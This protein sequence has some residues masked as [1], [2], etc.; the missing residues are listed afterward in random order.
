MTTAVYHSVLCCYLYSFSSGAKQGRKPRRN[1]WCGFDLK[2]AGEW[3][4][5]WWR[6]GVVFM[7]TLRQSQPNKAGLECLFVCAYMHK[8][9]FMYVRMSV[10]PQK[11][12]SISIKFDMWVAVDEWCM[13][14]CSMMTRSKVKVM[15]PSKLEI[16]HFQQLSPPFTSGA[17]NRP[18]ILKLGHNI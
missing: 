8:C 11:V 12:C 18:W 16:L 17:D 9:M 14:V 3:S 7:S 10:L 4:W 1:S 2:T 6:G 15:S 13:T 5:W